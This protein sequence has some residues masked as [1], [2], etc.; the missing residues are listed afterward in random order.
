MTSGPAP[1]QDGFGRRPLDRRQKTIPPARE[2]LDKPRTVGV[3]VERCPDLRDTNIQRSVEIDRGLAPYLTP[4][5]VAID[6]AARVPRQQ[7]QDLERL[8]RKPD[9]AAV[10]P[11]LTGRC[12]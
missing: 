9:Q 1:W 5:P 6:H 8:R 4:N 3:I 10:P 12:V 2:R 7:L 11:K